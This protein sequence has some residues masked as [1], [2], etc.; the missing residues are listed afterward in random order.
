MEVY[1]ALNG[2]DYG[3]IL[4]Y[5]IIL[6]GLGFWV[7]FRKKHPHDLFLAGRTLTWPTI[8]LSIWGTNISPSMM[9]ASCGVAYSSGIVMG[10]ASWLAWIFLVLLGMVFIPHYL[11]TKIFTMP[12][13]MQVRFGGCC[14]DFLSWYTLVSTIILWLGGTT[15]AGGVLLSQIMGWPVVISVIVLVVIATSFTVAG[16]L[17]AVVVTDSFQVVLMIIASTILTVIAVS[18]V[19]GLGAM[20]DGVPGDYWKLFKPAS[21]PDWPWDAVIFGYFTSAIWFWCTDQ[22]VVQRVLG[23]KNIE[24]GQLGVVFTGFLKILDPLIFFIPGIAC[25]LLFPNLENPDTAYMRMVTECLPH[26]MIGLIVAVLIAALVSTVDS[27]LNSLSTVFTLD[28]YKRMFRPEASDTEVTRVGR[29]VTVA[30]AVFSVIFCLALAQVK[31]TD[32][33]SLLGG[34]IGFLAPTMS[35]VFLVGVLWKGATKTAAFV[36][37]IVG[38]ITC[39]VVGI[40]Y[41]WDWGPFQADKPHFMRISFWLF[42]PIFILMIVLSLLTKHSPEEQA[43][44]SIGET[45]RKTNYKSTRVWIYWG[46]LAVIMVALY[47]IFNVVL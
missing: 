9:I 14:R 43:L 7:S 1:K 39:L 22:T 28:I 8:G 19:G 5:V 45:Y 3:V 37:L 11:N 4:L 38:N 34:L 30:G 23:A 36:T 29:I 25:F 12:E 41:I 42:I 44:P 17:A 2:L 27:G 21:D 15:Y 24:Q 33:F 10:N 31:N 13:F 46:I 16:G 26:G 47:V 6:I 20:I 18:K 40:P 35:V 32:L